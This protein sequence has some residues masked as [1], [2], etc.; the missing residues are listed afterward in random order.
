MDATY[1]SAKARYN[2]LGSDRTSYL[3]RAREAATLTIPFLMPPEG[4]SASTKFPTPYQSVGARGLNNLANKLL[5]ALLPAN[6][7][8]FKFQVDDYALEQMTQQEGMR[9][10]V[11]EALNKIERTVQ[12]EIETTSIRTSFFTA[13][14]QLIVAGNVLIHMLPTGGTKV[15]RLDRFVCKRDPMG[16]VLELVTHEMISP[17]EVP[18]EIRGAVLAKSKTDDKRQSPEDNVDLYTRITR[19]KDGFDVSQEIAGMVV[20]GSEGKYPADRSPWMCLRWTAMD[21]EDY[22]R[23]FV[24][25]YLGDLK[26]L[27]VLTKAIVQGAA[28][29]SK[30]LFLV[31]PNST[32]KASV[33]AS[34][35]SGDVRE[36]NA[37]DVTVL[38]LDKYADFRVAKD[39]RDALIEALSFA[40]LLGGAVQRN[41]ERVT[42][43]EIRFLANELETTL[44]GAYSNLSQELQLPFVR[45]LLMQM[46]SQKRVPVLPAQVKPVIT[47][48]LDAIGRGNDRNKL[49]QFIGTLAQMDPA[50]IQ[51]YVNMGD[52]IK[53]LGVADGIDM[54]GLIK[55]QAQIDAEQ[56]QAKQMQV[57]QSA[58]EKLGPGAITQAGS[59]VREQIHPQNQP[60]QGTQ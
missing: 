47:T 33:L 3:D 32:T 13:L 44:G 14:K 5:L 9:A 46:E 6:S 27:E 51:T 28:A 49:S 59:A 26:S 50:V 38:Q 20:P 25:E 29:A 11:E 16:N 31:K 34:S 58:M 40:F 56:Q 60:Q 2:Q 4:S 43:E 42:A 52:L 19:T 35:S 22:G 1:V 30:V 45:R 8:F 54:K 36:G 39:T 41:G 23:G 18:E 10:E 57:M 17:M 7:P 53:R 48:G 15:F 21:N 37:D 55:P 24:E 12:V